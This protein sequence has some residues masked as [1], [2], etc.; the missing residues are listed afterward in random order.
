MD[1]KVR[2]TVVPASSVDF[3][4][5]APP[6]IVASDHSVNYTCGSCGTVLLHAEDG[7]IHGLTIHCSSCGTY[8]STNS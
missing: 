2:L 4:V 5:D 3:S 1:P 6:V 8:N 7:Q